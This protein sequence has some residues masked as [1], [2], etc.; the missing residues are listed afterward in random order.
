GAAGGVVGV[1]I[2]A[3]VSLGVGPGSVPPG[4]LEVSEPDVEL[5]EGFAADVVHA[6]SAVSFV[7]MRLNQA[8][9][10]EVAKV[11]ADG[12]LGA[13]DA[14]GKLG[15]R[16]GVVSEFPNDR[17]PDGIV[18]QVECARPGRWAEAAVVRMHAFSGMHF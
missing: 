7:G 15:D 13:V 2:L 5:D 11:L 18:E 8:C 1:E 4:L 6:G 10:S 3:L 9:L 12:R 17:L 14:P 16:A